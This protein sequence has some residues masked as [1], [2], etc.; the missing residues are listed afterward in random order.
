ML[1]H[2]LTS[3]LCIAAIAGLA[4]LSPATGQV[5]GV[6]ALVVDY[7]PPTRIERYKVTDFGASTSS[8]D[9]RTSKEKFLVAERTGNCCE[10]YLTTSASG[11][12]FDLGGKYIN[13]TDDNGRTWK[14][15]QT[16]NPLVNGEGTLA[17]G[18]G[19]DV[20][21]VEWDPYS[22]DHLMAYKYDAAVESWTYLESPLHT[23]FYDRPWMSVVPGPFTTALGDV[24]Y[25][26]F[27]DGFP[28]SGAFLMSTD[29]LA[30]AQAS[31]PFVDDDLEEPVERWIPTKPNPILDWG[32]PNSN[33][34]IIPL[35]GG[36]ALAPPA[37]FGAGWSMLNPETLRWSPFSL[38]KGEL[39]GRM[40]V[41]SKGRIH[42]FIPSAQG[43]FYRISSDGGRSWKDLN[44]TLPK[45]FSNSGNGL[46][47]DF[48]A[49]A[50][51]GLAAVALHGRNGLTQAT[52]DI[53]YT[54]DIRKGV[55]KLVKLYEI[56]LAD[57][58]ASSGVGQDIRFDFETVTFF[59][60]GR[61][62]V[63][64]LDSTTAGVYHLA[65]PAGIERIGPALAIEL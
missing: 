5:P 23:P 53:V 4:L 40:Q 24:P 15:V 58:N 48:R 31:S 13:F 26:T 21:A 9:D 28:H 41:D 46:Q 38:P 14:Q 35:G 45:E 10:N 30:Y 51:V 7:E 3:T 11:R 1:S 16:I 34:P 50:K 64:F 57:T 52:A 43:F 36:R 62:A 65:E 29:G 18:P 61:I 32:Q 27:V 60:D 59:P 33:S 44:V 63:S 22:G 54:I 19:G 8:K 47:V 55:P 25:V 20:L 56:G 6:P 17:M 12:L 39:S 37:S 42:N 2:R 49:N